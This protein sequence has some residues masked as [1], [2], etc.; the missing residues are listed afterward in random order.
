MFLRR[1]K[2]LSAADRLAGYHCNHNRTPTVYHGARAVANDLNRFF[3]SVKRPE[4][5]RQRNTWGLADVDLEEV[6]LVRRTDLAESVREAIPQ[7]PAPPA[8][9]DALG[10]PQALTY[11]SG[12]ILP[13]IADS[14]VTAVPDT[15]V[16]YIG[17]N[18]ILER[19]LAALIERTQLAGRLEVADLEDPDSIGS[20]VETADV[21]VVDLGLDASLVDPSFAT[22]EADESVRFRT[23]LDETFMALHSLIE[24]ERSRLERGEHPHPVVLVNSASDFWN[25]YIIA[26][27]DCSHTTVHSRVRR[28]TVKLSPD[29]ELS[30]FA[31][32]KLTGEQVV[33]PIES[34]VVNTPAEL[35]LIEVYR[36]ERLFRT[37]VNGVIRVGAVV[38]RSVRGNRPPTDH[39][40]T[41]APL[42]VAATEGPSALNPME[43]AVIEVYRRRPVFRATVDVLML[44][45]ASPRA[46][47]LRRPVSALRAGRRAPAR[48]TDR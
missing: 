9:S 33:A 43:G 8:G 31:L 18:P 20:L 1:G 28:A 21:F 23:K 14:L 34:A 35:A 46:G 6:P 41:S 12:H 22:D 11:D 42:L 17:A 38:T 26:Q 5:P 48:D 2:I 47:R 37:T 36:S 19:M 25:A 45:L 32:S 4:L 13:F 40:E 15:T 27:L 24:L 7:G 3:L 30:Q 10:A 39:D 16:A 44:G 29:A